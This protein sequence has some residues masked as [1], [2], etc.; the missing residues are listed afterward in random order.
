MKE[1]LLED[2][3]PHMPAN[4]T[5]EV[6][7]SIRGPIARI[8]LCRPDKRNAMNDDVVRQ[9]HRSFLD[10]PAS[11]RAAIITG[12]GAHF[13]AGLDLSDVGERNADEAIA[14]S[15]RWHA[16]FAEIQTGRIPVV[17]VLQGAVIGG[18]LELA[19]ACHLRVAE[20]SAYFALPEAQRGIFV[21][22]GGSARIP[23]L[24]GVSRM[25]DMMLSGR[26]F[27]AM[28]AERIGLVNYL[29]GPAEGLAKA[30]QLAQ[31]IASNAPLSNFAVL[32][33]L[34]RI[35]D[36]SLSDGLFIESLMAA[37]TERSPEATERLQAF[38]QKRV[39]KIAPSAAVPG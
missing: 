17:A 36:Q 14:H 4:E 22:G 35:A 12:A 32:Q 13:C 8:D 23:R 30:L 18:G 38:L 34:P 33:A 2:F 11:V 6:Q 28:E 39:A 1:N 25:T 19:S 31:S 20:P 26:V 15:R 29:V 7:V 3:L 5:R 10:L 16:A 37:L 24:I 27:D 9:L 21:G